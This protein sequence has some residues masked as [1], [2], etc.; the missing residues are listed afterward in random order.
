MRAQRLPMPDENVWEK[1][2]F[3]EL[4]P[5]ELVLE[6]VRDRDLDRDRGRCLPWLSLAVGVEGNE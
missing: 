4:C 1:P 2:L 3:C 5:C 6:Y